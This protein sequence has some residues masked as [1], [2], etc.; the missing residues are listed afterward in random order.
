MPK[1]RFDKQPKYYNKTVS[2]VN[3]DKLVSDIKLLTNEYLDVLSL[4]D[5]KQLLYIARVILAHQ[6]K[7]PYS[8][9]YGYTKCI[10]DILRK[11]RTR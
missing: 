8:K 5:K 9:Q 6:R 2:N 7:I 10:N 11:C 4:E 3:C 1:I